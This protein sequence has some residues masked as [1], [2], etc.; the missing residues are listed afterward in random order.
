MTNP[1]VDRER[2]PFALWQGRFQGGTIDRKV[3]LRVLQTWRACS[4][5]PLEGRCGP[6]YEVGL[7][8]A[9]KVALAGTAHRR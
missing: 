8:P 3:T 7:D 9:A 5:A 2:G 4:F 6:R 1:C